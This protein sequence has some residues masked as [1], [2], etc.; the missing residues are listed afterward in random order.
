MN[1]QTN[2]KIKKGL[3]ILQIVISFFMIAFGVLASILYPIYCKSWDWVDVLFFAY[4]ILA[5]AMGGILMYLG[6]KLTGSYIVTNE[7]TTMNS[8]QDSLQTR[9]LL[10]AIL[11]IIFILLSLS[12]III[13]LYGSFSFSA[14]I[15]CCLP[16]I[17]V[18]ALITL[19]FISLRI[20]MKNSK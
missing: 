18:V 19:A 4:A 11:N 15:M 7:P 16:F 3:G 6:E 10:V 8:K 17:P 14:F 1:T 5:V 9:E 20:E 12:I 2:M 13:M